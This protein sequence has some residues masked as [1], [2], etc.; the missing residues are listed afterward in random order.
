MDETL[1]SV[2]LAETIEH[3]LLKPDATTKEI[4]QLCQE[5][6]GY[7][8]HGVCVPPFFIKHARKMLKD[9]PVK[10]VTVIGFPMGYTGPNAKAEEVKRAVTDKVDEIDMVMNIAALKSGNLAAVRNELQSITTLARL[11]NLVLKVIIEPTLLT[12]DEIRQACQLCAEAEVAFVKNATGFHGGK[13]T[14]E[15]ITLLRQLL[16]SSVQ[17]KASAG[18]RDAE[19][20]R[21]LLQAGATRLG[22]SSGVEI[23]RH[24]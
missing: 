10:V 3:T 18:I 1:K 12:E 20:A 5:A 13:A 24:E 21:Q 9:Q 6:V 15:I 11:N 17:I 8:F 22:T 19:F 14:V 2:K 16:P 23:V 4:T 7:G